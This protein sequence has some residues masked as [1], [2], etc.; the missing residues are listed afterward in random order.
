MEPILV[1]D[2]LD[3][4]QFSDLMDQRFGVVADEFMTASSTV[5]GLHWVVSRIFSGGTKAR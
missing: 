1:N 2:G 3:L 5:V 4:G